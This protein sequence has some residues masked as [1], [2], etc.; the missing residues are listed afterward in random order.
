MAGLAVPPAARPAR[1][2]A[3]DIVQ[4]PRAGRLVL[5]LVLRFPQHVA[6]VRVLLEELASLVRLVEN[7]LRWHP[8]HLHDL[9]DLVCLVRAGEERLAGMHLHQ[10]AAERPHV[11]C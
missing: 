9:V 6:P 7:V 1:L 2:H 5:A 4:L 3:Q 10:Y 8:Q 11:Y